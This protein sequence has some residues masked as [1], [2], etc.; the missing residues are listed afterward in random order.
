MINR[1]VETYHRGGDL[2]AVWTCRNCGAEQE[3]GVDQARTPW[4]CGSCEQ[5]DRGVEAWFDR[6]EAGG[7]GRQ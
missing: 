2:I 3:V 1:R 7:G 4:F 5:I 6:L